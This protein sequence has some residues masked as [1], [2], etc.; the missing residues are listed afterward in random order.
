LT[1]GVASVSTSRTESQ[2]K[3][4]TA[5][6][7]AAAVTALPVNALAATVSVN[8]DGHLHYNAA[9]GEVNEV[10]IGESPP[11]VYTITDQG[12]LIVAGE[13]CVQLGDHEVSCSPV[14][15]AFIF[16]GDLADTAEASQG[17]VAWITVYGGT[18]ADRLTACLDCR[19]SLWGGAGGDALQAGDAGSHLVGGGG[20]DTISGGRG[21]DAIHDGP[22]DDTIA[23]GDGNDGINIRSGNDRIDAGGG[24]DVL[25]LHKLTKPAVVDLRAGT[26]TGYGTKTLIGIE[27]VSATRYADRLYGTRATNFFEAGYGDDLVA[28]RGGRD[29]LYGSP[30][31][32]RLL[33]GFGADQLYGIT[34]DDLLIGGRGDDILVGGRHND[35]MFGWSGADTLRAGDRRQDLVVG[36]RGVDSA[37]VDAGLDVVRSIEIFF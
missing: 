35:R 33:G 24:Q 25:R 20:A 10:Q 29:L 12:A 36:G 2:V 30:G 32:D 4:H 17:V 1:G 37:H 14:S 6:V 28:G 7:A 16:L 13:G 31:D 18:G 27:A 3:L 22:G 19:G 21:E 26:L 9:P 23:S 8:S 15:F 34:G 5:L 11:G